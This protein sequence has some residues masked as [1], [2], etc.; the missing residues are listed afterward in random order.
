MKD[1]IS[2][3]LQHNILYTCVAERKKGNEE[4]VQE[5]ALSYI[6]TGE[7][8]LYFNG[9]VFTCGPGMIGLLRKNLLL[10]SVKAPAADGTPFQSLNILFD[11]DSLRKYSSQ[12]DTIVDG[13]YT[14]TPVVNS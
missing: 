7:I 8:T 5:H 2:H 14:G 1:I 6:M 11:Q 10:K 3:K 13:P 12:T 4:I 9:G